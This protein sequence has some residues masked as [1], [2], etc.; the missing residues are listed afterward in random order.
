MEPNHHVKVEAVAEPEELV[1]LQVELE[2]LEVQILLQD[3]QLYMLA[4]AEVIQA[5]V[6]HQMVEEAQLLVHLMQQ[7]TLEEDL[8]EMVVMEEQE[9]VD[10]VL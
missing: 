7:L 1:V 2:E 10:L 8:V 3:V 4:V 9:M 6:H 5:E